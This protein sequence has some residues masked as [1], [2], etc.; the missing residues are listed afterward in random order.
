MTVLNPI[1]T[2]RKFG[3]P[4][5]LEGV[6][7]NTQGKTSVSFALPWAGLSFEV[8]YCPPPCCFGAATPS[9]WMEPFPVGSRTDTLPRTTNSPKLK[10]SPNFPYKKPR[11]TH[12]LEAMLD[13]I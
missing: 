4:Y 11:P 9:A 12:C 6:G 10:T 2:G 13:L 8:G 1:R 5:P 7:G 3:I